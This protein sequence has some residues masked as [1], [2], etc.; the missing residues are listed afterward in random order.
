[1]LHGLVSSPETTKVAVTRR[2]AIEKIGCGTPKCRHQVNPS[3]IKWA[4]VTPSE[5][6]WLQVKLDDD[7]WNR[8]IPSEPEWCQVSPSDTKWNRVHLGAY[9]YSGANTQA[10]L[11]CEWVNPSKPESE[12]WINF[13][14]SLIPKNPKGIP[15]N[16][17]S[18]F[19]QDVAD[20]TVDSKK[21]I[22][23]KLNKRD[24]MQAEHHWYLV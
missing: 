9:R 20:Q 18:M 22:T 17:E 2:R 14:L 15:R 8:V 21:L 10:C 23:S 24:L 1:M 16:S 19:F 3:D 7:K 5:N 4:W 13:K 6:E 11:S 12:K